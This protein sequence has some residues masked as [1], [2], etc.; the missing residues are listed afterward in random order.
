MAPAGINTKP[1]LSGEFAMATPW[2]HPL[3]PLAAEEIPASI[4]YGAAERS[5]MKKQSGNAASNPPKTS[6]A[7]FLNELYKSQQLRSRLHTTLSELKQTTT[8]F[9]PRPEKAHRSA[10]PT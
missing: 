8:L 2:H 4:H 7:Q 6:S 5:N 3:P 10:H 1:P 9:E